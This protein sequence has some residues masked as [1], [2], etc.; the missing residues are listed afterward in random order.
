M[1]NDKNIKLFIL[2]KE[3]IGAFRVEKKTVNTK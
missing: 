1:K 3:K 2:D